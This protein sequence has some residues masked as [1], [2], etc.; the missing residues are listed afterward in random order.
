MNHVVYLLA[1]SNANYVQP[2]FRIL[3]YEDQ[4]QVWSRVHEVNLVSFLNRTHG[5][6]F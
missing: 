3:R 4:E 1:N 5:F 2:L 6:G